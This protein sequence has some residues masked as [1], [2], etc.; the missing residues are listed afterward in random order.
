MNIVVTGG[1]GFIGS[2]LVKSFKASRHNQIVVFD[3]LKRENVERN[4]SVIESPNVTVVR[5]DVRL[6]Y[7]FQSIPFRPDVI[8]H[9]AGN[10]GIPWSL[11]N[12]ESD[13]E[14]NVVGTFNVLQYAR[15]FP[16]VQVIMAS[17][18]RVYATNTGHPLTSDAKKFIPASRFEFGID[19]NYSSFGQLSPYGASKKSAD[20]LCQ[21]WF[22]SFGVNVVIN[23]MGV[24]YGEGQWGA[25]EQG[26]LGYF[27]RMK[28]QNQPITIF[29]NG[30]QVRDPLYI[31]DLVRLVHRQVDSGS[32]AAGEVFNV[33]GGISNAVSLNEVVDYLG[34]VPTYDEIRP[35]DMLWYVSDIRKVQKLFQWSPATN[36]W[37]GIDLTLEWLKH[38]IS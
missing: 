6:R 34:V 2:N 8:L 26:W 23:R 27:C 14:E 12:P 4:F 15:Q 9:Y 19:E 30:K 35:A 25:T 28:T 29:G 22:Y 5:G 20:Q 13:F 24:I 16:D 21:E 10:A 17:T 7:D 32:Y 3:S 18:N 37:D 31:S 1:L 36:I 11:E 38:E 33:G